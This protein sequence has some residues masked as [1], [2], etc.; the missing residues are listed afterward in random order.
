M[1]GPVR[2]SV[3]MIVSLSRFI[4]TLTG[5]GGGGVRGVNEAYRC[6]RYIRLKQ[7]GI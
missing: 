6:Y 7:N 4:G 2:S 3:S 5:A 1:E